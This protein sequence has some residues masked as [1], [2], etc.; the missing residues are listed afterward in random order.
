MPES[1]VEGRRERKK[2]ELRQRIY[3][4]AGMLFWKQ[5]YDATTVDQIAEAADVSQAT[6]FNYYPSK[7]DLI[8]QMATEVVAVVKALV[9]EQRKAP[10]A[11]AGRIAEMARRATRLIEDTQLL[12]RDLLRALMR[13]DEGAG[14]LLE[15][16]RDAIAELMRDGQQLGD[17][18]GDR[19]AEFLAEMGIGVFYG[20]ITHWLETDTYPLRSRMSEAAEFLCEAIAPQG[21]G[22]SEDAA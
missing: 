7:E 17:V 5:G 3:D 22:T 19:D 20:T 8:G 10:S 18:R 4:C 21:R 15:E 11:T 13:R 6:F 12:T 2:R 9:E 1:T 14:R 16:V